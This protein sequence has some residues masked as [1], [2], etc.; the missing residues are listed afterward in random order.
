M[1]GWL[2]C[3]LSALGACSDGVASDATAPPESSTSS[4]SSGASASPAP[5]GATDAAS[6]SDAPSAST[7]GANDYDKDGAVPFTTRTEK[8]KSF[9][10][11]IYMPST[12]GLHPLVSL[13]PGNTQGVKPY[14]VHAKRLASHG[15]ATIMKG[16]PGTFTPTS[17]VVADLVSIMTEWVPTALAS[18]VDMKRI[19]LTGHSRGG[20]VSLA[21]AEGGL[22]GKV[23]AWFGLDP[24]DNQFAMSP[25]VYARTSLSKLTIPTAYLAASVESNCAPAADSYSMLFPATPKPSV[26]VLGLGAG[27]TQ[28]ASEDGCNLCSICS[29]GGTADSKVVLSYTLRYMTAFF[30]RE[31]LGDTKVGAAFEGAGGPADVAAGLVKITAK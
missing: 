21:A 17:T 4:S 28:V 14:E 27:H 16:D 5:S 9:D 3:F 31:L 20:A 25:G 11:T 15:I 13:S 2:F 1:R 8:A 19:G 22:A 26:L 18:E 24:V 10:V 6:S 7:T 30:A 29:P 12:P 23:V